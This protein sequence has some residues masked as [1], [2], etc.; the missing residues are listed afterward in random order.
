M[1]SF[2]KFS[3]GTFRSWNSRFQPGPNIADR[4]G[5]PQRMLWPNSSKMLAWRF[6]PLTIPGHEKNPAQKSV[7]WIWSWMENHPDYPEKVD[8]NRSTINSLK[9]LARLLNLVSLVEDMLNNIPTSVFSCEHKQCWW[10][11]LPGVFALCGNPHP[12]VNFRLAWSNYI[13]FGKLR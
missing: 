7:P 13:P 3:K 2:T 12:N 9:L 8:L 4:W 6:R 10:I 1:F 11:C 5:H